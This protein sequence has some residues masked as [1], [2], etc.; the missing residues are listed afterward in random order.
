V[1]VEHIAFLVGRGLSATLVATIVGLFG[2]AYLP[3]RAIV[4]V[5]GGRVGLQPMVAVAIALQALGVA[6]LLGAHSAAGIVAYVL[7]FG[8]AYGGLSPLRAAIMAEHFG[9][10]AYGSIVAAQ[11]VPIAVLSALGPYVGGRL[12]DAIGYDASFKLCILVLAAG[13]LIMLV[14][15]PKLVAAHA[16]S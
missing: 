15:M 1:I 6:L 9:R 5:F 4:A 16:D 2:L 10:R 11:G 8:A 14:P 7:V 12:I 3:G 13:T